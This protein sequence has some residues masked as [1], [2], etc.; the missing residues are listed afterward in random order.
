MEMQKAPNPQGTHGSR[1]TQPQQQSGPSQL[2][3][4]NLKRSNSDEVVEVPNP[5]STLGS[6]TQQPQQTGPQPHRPNIPRITPE[7][8]AKMT[9][10]QRQQ[11]IMLQNRTR[12]ASQNPKDQAQFNRFK[13]L[14]GEEAGAFGARPLQ[15]VPM[16]P[17]TRAD[18][19]QKLTD[20]KNRDMFSRIEGLMLQYHKLTG[21][22]AATRELIRQVCLGITGYSADFT[23]R[24]PALLQ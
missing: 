20:K 3:R 12:P 23:P 18:M 7:Q 9:P 21:D 22:E 11:F 4:G 6:Q 10:E 24:H 1:P 2:L 8:L 14:L 16:N 15:P 17:E 5:N 19:V 13:Q